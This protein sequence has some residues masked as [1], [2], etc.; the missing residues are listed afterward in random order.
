MSDTTSFP[1][2][3]HCKLCLLKEVDHQ[4]HFTY[5]E[6]LNKQ[7]PIF[8]IFFYCWFCDIVV[9]KSNYCF[10]VSRNYEAVYS[11]GVRSCQSYYED[12]SESGEDSEEGCSEGEE[13]NTEDG[14]EGCEQ[15]VQ[16][17]FN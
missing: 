12:N 9:Y 1:Y 6:A 13:S 5:I 4:K 7:K 14:Q 3:S 11:A 15:F 17:V 10:L 2:C 8:I 16:N